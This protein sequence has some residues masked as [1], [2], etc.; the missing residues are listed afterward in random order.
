MWPLD[1]TPKIAFC[2]RILNLIK[3]EPKHIDQII[4]EA[5]MEVGRATSVITMMEIK[6]MVKNL[7]GMVYT[8][9]R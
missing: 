7:G 1:S 4:R 5:K 8:I 6:G 9:N 2:S 3:E